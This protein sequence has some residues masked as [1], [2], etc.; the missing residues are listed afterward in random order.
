[1]YEDQRADSE[2]RWSE[3]P[4][5][6]FAVFAGVALL[7]ILAIAPKYAKREAGLEQ[8]YR[9]RQ[10]AAREKFAAHEAGDATSRSPD[11]EQPAGAAEAQP[12]ATHRELLV[13]LTPLIIIIAAVLIAATAALAWVRYKQPPA[14]TP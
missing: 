7:G 5:L 6:Y 14:S 13:P 8:R 4:W 2:N 1:M 3:S 9:A 12:V 11:H 10:G